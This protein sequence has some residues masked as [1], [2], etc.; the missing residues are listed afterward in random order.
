MF[1]GIIESSG[2]VLEII[3]S[4]TNRSF[5]LRSPL[6]AGFR[7]DQSVSH[8]GVCLT[9]E[10]IEADTHRV[11]AIEET[12]L[13]T[14]LG[15]W[16]QGQ[17]INLERCLQVGARLDGHFVQGHVDCTG[18]VED[19]MLK[20]GSREINIRF[21][22]QFAALMIEKGSISVDGISLTA[23]NVT[24]DR[25]TVA[26]IPY[27]LEHTNLGKLQT[28]QRVNLEFDLIGKYINRM[29]AVNITVPSMP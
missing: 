16:K 21:P 12:L 26:I 15:D 23:F 6:S 3:H 17:V 29:S 28:G 11:T 5:V 2:T 13:K 14:T 1:T 24:N 8:N 25:F 20:E 27:T 10:S 18:T 9:V 19:I 7:P 4:G 22:E